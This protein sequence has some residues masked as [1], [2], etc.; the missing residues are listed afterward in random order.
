[1]RTL[2]DDVAMV[3]DDHRSIRAMVESRWAMAITVLPAIRVS[4]L[5]WIALHLLSSAEVACPAPGRRVLEDDP[6]DSD[7][8]RWPPDSLTPRSPTWAS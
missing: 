3:E 4:R 1:M 2:L 6:G 5:D 8:W 7:P